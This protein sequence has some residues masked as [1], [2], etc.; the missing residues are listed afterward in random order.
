MFYVV[1]GK[2]G[3]LLGNETAAELG[4]VKI[5]VNEVSKFNTTKT[6]ELPK[7]EVRMKSTPEATRSKVVRP[8]T[9][10]TLIGTHRKF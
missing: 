8:E 2:A 6:T 5:K 7:V 1:N 9:R 4:I 3:S 10:K